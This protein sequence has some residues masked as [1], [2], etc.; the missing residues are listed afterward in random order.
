KMDVAIAVFVRSALKHLASRV[1]AGRV[2]LPD[3][4][5]LVEDF[6][7]C[8]QDGSAARVRAPHLD[9]DR[10][11]DGGADARTVLRH[12]LAGARRAVRKDEAGYLDLV[13]RMIETGT[14]S[15]RIRAEMAPFAQADDETFTEAARRIYIELIDCLEANEPWA[16][17][18]L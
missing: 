13:A 14:L 9:V 4:A 12:L 5:V 6:R 16:R 15:E 8:I 7:A 10:D 3:H 11:A 1:A 18:G 17:R 2:E